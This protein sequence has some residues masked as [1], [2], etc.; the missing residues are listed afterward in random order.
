M[1]KLKF[2]LQ[3]DEKLEDL[4]DIPVEDINEE[5]VD[6]PT[7]DE[8]TDI[9]TEPTTDKL[10]FLDSDELNEIREILLDIPDNIMLLLLNDSVIVL[11]TED[12]NTT[13]AY[14]LDEE[15]T[16]FGLVELSKTLSDVL[17]DTSI[18]KYTPDGAD[19]RHDKVVELLMNKLSDKEP[20]EKEVEE[21]TP[22]PKEPTEEE[23]KDE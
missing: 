3:E 1:S 5:V 16:D 17:T 2:V 21:V 6:E 22:E 12:G 15:A 7:E 9:F 8:N 19:K 11:A 13:M 18:I 10:D 4:T 14:T 20:E 23:D